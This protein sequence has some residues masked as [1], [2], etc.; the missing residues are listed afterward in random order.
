MLALPVEK[1]TKVE[2][3]MKLHPL[4]VTDTKMSALNVDARYVPLGGAMRARCANMVG[5][6]MPTMW[7]AFFDQTSVPVVAVESMVWALASDRRWVA[8]V[9][10]LPTITATSLLP[11]VMRACAP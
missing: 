10:P 8:L 9:P 11:D 5:A 7:Q 1:P 2:K 3:L 4:A 6:A